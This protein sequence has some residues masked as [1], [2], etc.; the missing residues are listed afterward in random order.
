MFRGNDSTLPN[1]IRIEKSDRVAHDSIFQGCTTS[2]TLLLE[3]YGLASG[4]MQR[5]LILV[6]LKFY[7]D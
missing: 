2:P 6:Y 1:L 4:H 5:S 3:M 7:Q